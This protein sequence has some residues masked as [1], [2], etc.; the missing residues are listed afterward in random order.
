VGTKALESKKGQGMMDRKEGRRMG[1]RVA[2]SKGVGADGDEGVI[3][4]E[5]KT[6]SW[7]LSVSQD[8]GGSGGR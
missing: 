5:K 2:H 7:A 4:Q 3:G 1:R 8:E 6:R